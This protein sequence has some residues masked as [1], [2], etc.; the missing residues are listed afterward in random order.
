MV[1]SNRQGVMPFVS[2]IEVWKVLKVFKEELDKLTPYVS[3]EERLP[4]PTTAGSYQDK[5]FLELEGM[6]LIGSSKFLF[7][8]YDP[9]HRDINKKNPDSYDVCFHT[10]ESGIIKPLRFRFN[11]ITDEL[12][13]QINEIKNRANRLSVSK[14]LGIPELTT[15]YQWYA[16]LFAYYGYPLNPT[17]AYK[18]VIEALDAA[19]NQ[20]GINHPSIHG[21]NTDDWIAAVKILGRSIDE[22]GKSWGLDFRFNV[23]KNALKSYYPPDINTYLVTVLDDNGEL[24]VVA[25]DDLRDHLNGSGAQIKTKINDSRCYFRPIHAKS[26]DEACMLF[27]R[28]IGLDESR[29][30]KSIA[31]EDERLNKNHLLSIKGSSSEDSDKIYPSP[32]PTD[33]ISFTLN[34]P[35]L[36]PSIPAEERFQLIRMDDDKYAVAQVLKMGFVDKGKAMEWLNSYEEQLEK[37]TDPFDVATPS[38]SVNLPKENKEPSPLVAPVSLNSPPPLMASVPM[39]HQPKSLGDKLRER[40]HGVYM[41][42]PVGD[43]RYATPP[44]AIGNFFSRPGQPLT[45][46][47]PPPPPMNSRVSSG[48]NV[49]NNYYPNYHSLPLNSSKEEVR[50]G[51]YGQDFVAYCLGEELSRNGDW[52][53]LL[54][55]IKLFMNS[56]RIPYRV[57]YESKNGEQE[58][59][60]ETGDFIG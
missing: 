38:P 3:V 27:M 47:P 30:S 56:E 20:A 4:I 37:N 34:P 59:D 16:D 58:V 42:D 35:A 41:G 39:Y 31:Y 12:I 15:R 25:G 5:D 26:A 32:S 8:G 40:H 10:T 14:K 57:I 9:V 24:Q 7:A 43:T 55:D 17:P 46:P 60:P 13:F 22:D 1:I 50:I 11:N 2:L 48:R 23:P 18:N 52:L 54:W 53:S 51:K 29:V 45:P 49:Q 36:D 28:Y 21:I 19:S 44:P 33:K 6:P